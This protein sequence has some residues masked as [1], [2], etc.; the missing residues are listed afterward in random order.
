VLETHGVPVIGYGTDELPGFFSRGS[1]L[2]LEARAD[3]PEEVAAIV[4]A[5]EALALPGGVLVTVPVPAEA[6]LPRTEAE[7]A[8]ADAVRLA[9]GAGITG[10]A[11]T[12]YILARVAQFT[13][14]RSVQANIALL[15]NNARVAAQIAAAMM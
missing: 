1:G 3:T 8:I 6:E 7:A 15:L 4:R 11:V 9:D 13:H 5:R 12:P 2:K 10:A 14:G